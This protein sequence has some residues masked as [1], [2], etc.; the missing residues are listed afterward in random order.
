MSNVLPPEGLHTL[1]KENRARF[2]L[3]GSLALM[4]CAA[5]ALLALMP[6]YATMRAGASGDEAQGGPSLADKAE[7]E[8]ISRAQVLVNDLY[9]IASSTVSVFDI[10]DPI[11]RARP[12]GVVLKSISYKRGTPG[13]ITLIGSAPS[14]EQITAY[15]DILAKSPHVENASVPIQ[16][17]TGRDDGRFTITL[18]GAF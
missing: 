14:R 5:I 6:G 1:R 18:S 11:I 8:E 12:S 3:V 7:K 4:L 9:A 16:N 17:L 15:R 13:M 2:F 10:L